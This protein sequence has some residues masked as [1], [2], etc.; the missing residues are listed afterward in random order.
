MMSLDSELLARVDCSRENPAWQIDICV[1]ILITNNS[2]VDIT[3]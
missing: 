1:P 3:S 2:T